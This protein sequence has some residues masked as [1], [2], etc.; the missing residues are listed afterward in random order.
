V[1]GHYGRVISTA[2]WPQPARGWPAW[3]FTAPYV[4]VAHPQEPSL[5]PIESGANCQRYAYGVVSLF[6]RQVPDHRSSEL[7]DDPS[8][9][10]PSLDHLQDLDLVLFNAD[11]SAWGA[12]VAVLIGRQLLHL[13]A[14]VGHPAVW[15]WS[16]FARRPRYSTIIGAVRP[17]TAPLP[18]Q[19]AATRS[20]TAPLP[21]API[22]DR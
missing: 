7:W 19:R 17:P 21:Y 11:D 18:D 20:P 6:N 14:E 22:G 13:C 12:H 2:G 16:D 10:H 3:V 9:A 1:T 5:G 8:L 15:S 4:G